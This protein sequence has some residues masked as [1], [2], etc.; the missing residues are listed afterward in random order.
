MF[1]VLAAIIAAVT[2]LQFALTGALGGAAEAGAT[3][4]LWRLLAL[5]SAVVAINAAT[6]AVSA[7]TL[8]RFGGR[9]GYTFRQ[10][11]AKYF[12]RVPFARFEQANSGE[13]LSIFSNDVPAA[14]RFITEGGL[15]AAASIFSLLAAFIYMMTLNTTYTL[16][17][18][19]MFPIF[20]V[21]Q[22][23]VSMPIQ[24]RSREREEA[25]AAFNAVVNDSLQNIPTITAYGLE[26]VMERRYL[27]KYENFL[28]AAK[29][30][31]GTF[32][33]LVIFGVTASII[34]MIV[35]TVLT[36]GSVIAGDLAV[37]EFIAFYSAA[38]MATGWLEMLSQTLNDIQTNMASAKRFNENT[39]HP[40]E[41]A[42]SGG[43]WTADMPISFTNVDFAYGE[44]APLALSSINFEIVPGSRTA[45]IGGSGSG[46]STILKLL[47]GLYQPKSGKITA[48]GRESF[49]YVPQD[50]FLFPESIGRNIACDDNP[51]LARLEK[52]CK[53]AG[54]LDF[55][56]G[57]P[58]KFDTVLTEG[59]DNISGGQRQRIAL[60]R[61][62]YRDAPVILFD[63]ATS[64]LDP[65]TE[66]QVLES[67]DKLAQGKTV[68]MVAHRARAIA[69]CDTVIR[70]ADGKIVNEGGAPR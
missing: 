64:A 23:L 65:I 8:G 59:S 52:V 48:G 45:F 5:L 35:I 29:R 40:L 22:I 61:A 67:F 43:E 63:E 62:F 60:A 70:L 4:E 31:V 13:S 36:A 54:I 69:S 10:N 3:S 50:S 58:N 57:L 47:L 20:A 49:A 25:R 7:L 42:Q 26:D 38:G 6:S 66:A 19:A 16:I 17:F 55:I 30:M 1:L 14:V 51:D 24:K 18:F 53:D 27:T 56:N 11:F 2:V 33:P 44:D 32:L 46:K 39:A 9:A 37:G 12:L 28:K 34:P 41:G 15:Q 68:I 21:L